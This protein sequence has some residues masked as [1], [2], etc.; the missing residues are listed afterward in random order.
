MNDTDRKRARQIAHYPWFQGKREWQREI[1]RM[2]KN[3]FKLE[4]ESLISK[5]ISYVTETYVPERLQ[6]KDWLD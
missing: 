2:L 1:E 4:V 6:Q 3:G 5:E